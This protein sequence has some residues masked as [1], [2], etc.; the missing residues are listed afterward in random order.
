MYINSEEKLD[1][2]SEFVRSLRVKKI[3]DWWDHKAMSAWILPSLVKSQSPMSTEDWDKTPSTTNTGEA[4]HH[5]TN[6]CTGIKLS[7]VEAIDMARKVD[8]EVVRE[9]ETSLKS[10]VLLNGQNE[11]YHHM[12]CSSQRQSSVMC[13]AHKS[14]EL[15]QECTRIESEIEAA[16][17][18]RKQS[19]AQLK[20]LSAELKSV[21]SSGRVKT[22]T[23]HKSFSSGSGA[24]ITL[25]SRIECF[26]SEFNTHR[27][28]DNQSGPTSSTFDM[29]FPVAIPNHSYFTTASLNPGPMELHT[30]ELIPSIPPSTLDTYF[31]P[32][33]SNFTTASLPFQAI[34]SS[35]PDT[36]FTPTT[37]SYFSASNGAG[38]MDWDPNPVR[39]GHFGSFNS[40]TPGIGEPGTRDFSFLDE[41]ISSP[42]SSI[43]D[44]VTVPT[45][46]P[47][48]HRARDEVDEANI[49]DGTRAWKRPKPVDSEV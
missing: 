36:Y 21:N 34:P 35:M 22:R 25:A 40:S 16:K 42:P 6:S 46:Q 10:G 1:D 8:K 13:K 18:T 45:I 5:W 39:F 30:E 24:V 15:Y 29:C 49:V 38:A 37:S 20:T 11:A 48:K 2:F 19:V 23:I 28:R 32:S 33:I 7:L 41:F 31:T 9:I 14:N 4:Q 17:E 47:K 26:N 44:L 43:P 12:A 27:R 3:H